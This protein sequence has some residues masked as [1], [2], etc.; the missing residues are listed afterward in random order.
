MT[1]YAE[2]EPYGGVNLPPNTPYEELSEGR[3][4]QEDL[5]G[6]DIN[7][8]MAK[9]RQTGLLPV[10]DREAYFADVSEVGD[11]RTVKNR[12]LAAEGA[13][14]ELPPHLRK[15][16]NNDAAEFLDFTSNPDNRDEMVEM[17]L[18]SDRRIDTEAEAQRVA[19]GVPP[20]EAADPEPVARRE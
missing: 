12:I 18:M 19:D 11:Y 1:H 2:G 8:I 7:N 6:A 15:R 14:M 13:F 5:P 17:G 9:Y 3:T 4:R 16:F 10:R 20:D